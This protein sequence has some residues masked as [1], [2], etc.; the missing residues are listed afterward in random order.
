MTNRSTFLLAGLLLSLAS[1][2][3]SAQ[4]SGAN[5]PQRT[6][7]ERL[8]AV[9]VTSNTN[10][11]VLGGFVFRQTKTLSGGETPRLRYLAAEV[12]NVRH[13][14]ERAYSLTNGNRLIL[15]KQF[16]LFPFRG[17]WGRE[18]TLFRRAD[19]QGVQLN[20]ILA[21]GPT[22]GLLKPYY[23]QVVTNQTPRRTYEVPYDPALVQNRDVYIVGSGSLFR[24]FDRLRIEPGLN[25]K[26]AVSI[27][28]DAFQTSSIGL[29]TGLLVEGY[30][31]EITLIPGVANR[32]FFTSGFLTLYYGIKR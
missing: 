11:G 10:S 26:A 17:Q 31:R 14:S 32:Q 29:E 24:G 16:Y 7:H 27:E 18:F 12:V 8:S 5:R 22:L 3:A 23:V 30:R 2:R 28:L 9:G 15:G 19:A 1:V 21:G 6:A 20:G 25:A 13:P 4:A